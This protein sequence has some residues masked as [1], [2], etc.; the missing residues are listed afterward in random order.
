MCGE[1]EGHPLQQ[2]DAGSFRHFLIGENNI[3]AAL[4]EHQFGGGTGIGGRHVVIR[5]QEGDE[6]RQEVRLVVDD[7]QRSF[8]KAHG[9]GPRLR[10]SEA[11][12]GSASDQSV[13]E[14]VRP[15]GVRLLLC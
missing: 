9:L 11:M 3:D 7:Q 15:R 5:R 4:L 13:V 8:S 1:W 12:E 6:R 10:S 2:F 14:S